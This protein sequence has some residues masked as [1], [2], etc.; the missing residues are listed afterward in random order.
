MVVPRQRLRV[1]R[2]GAKRAFAQC[3]RAIDPARQ[4]D[5]AR[6][7]RL[8]LGLDELLPLHS[9][10]RHVHGAPAK[11]SLRRLNELQAELRPVRHEQLEDEAFFWRKGGHH[12]RASSVT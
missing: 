9:T 1:R 2:P 5:G 12:E 11:L 10:E 7:R 8:L 3:R 4:A 6:R